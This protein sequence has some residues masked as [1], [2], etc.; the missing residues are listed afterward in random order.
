MSDN[1]FY[2]FCGLTGSGKT[3]LASSFAKSRNLAYLDYDTMVQPFLSEL[4]KRYGIGDSRAGFYRSWRDACYESFWNTSAEILGTGSSL[5]A[6]APCGHEIEDPTFF[7]RLKEKAKRPF[8]AVGIY[9]APEKD[10]HFEIMKRR[11]AIWNDDIIPNWNE[12]C[13]SHMPHR[14]KWD[15]DENIYLEYSSFDE[16]NEKF[17]QALAGQRG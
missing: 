1:V 12:Y 6:S 10:F 7:S 9:L 13:L 8:V 3:A 2:L 17:A 15:A 14:P 11:N 4:E 16:L 5:A